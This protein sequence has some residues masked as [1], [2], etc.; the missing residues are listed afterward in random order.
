MTSPAKD[1][2]MVQVRVPH[3]S[4]VTPRQLVAVD[5]SEVLPVRRSLQYRVSPSQVCQ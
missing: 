1:M 2:F 4:V 3:G 5:S